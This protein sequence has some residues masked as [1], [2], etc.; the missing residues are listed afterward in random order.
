MPSRARHM[1]LFTWTA[2]TLLLAALVLLCVLF[3]DIPV[4]Y[5]VKDH[6]YVNLHWSRLTSNLP[7]LLLQ[8]VLLTS[9]GSL[10]LYRL[11][12]KR[13][14]FDSLTSLERL[15][16]WAAPASYL[17]KTVLKFVFGRVNTRIWLQEPGLYGFHWFQRRQGCEGF[18][19]GHM[20]V[21]VTL[22]AAF[23]RFYPR[24]RPYCLILAFGLGVALI[25]TDY[26]FVSDVLAGAYLGVL[27]E[28]LIFWWLARNPLQVPNPGLR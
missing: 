1:N 4:A 13:G 25:A 5:F 8:V 23:W 24:S 15:L 28:A 14:I 26:H 7:D 12:L 6:L 27:L 9:V 10:V 17:T 22:L 21:I 3:L 11:R 19:S 16:A 2:S 20:V 18:P